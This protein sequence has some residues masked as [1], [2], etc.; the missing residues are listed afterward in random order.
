MEAEAR[1]MFVA[2]LGFYCL[3][4]CPI[5]Y[6]WDKDGKPK[7]NRARTIWGYSPASIQTHIPA[8]LD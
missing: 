2:Q 7:A 8:R 6:Q 3:L 1:Q 5:L 4:E